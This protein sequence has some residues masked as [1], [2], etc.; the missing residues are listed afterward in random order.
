MYVTNKLGFD[1][2][3]VKEC[4]S[5]AKLKEWRGHCIA[6]IQS[7]EIKIQAA[8]TKRKERNEMTEGFASLKM[9]KQYQ[10]ILLNQIDDRLDI[11]FSE[12]VAFKRAAMMILDKE[13][14]EDIL[15]HAKDICE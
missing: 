9:A 11:L 13:T 1:T 7:L 10:Q 2:D 5:F 12:A 14:Y 6:Q 15:T 3:Q 4:N 8:I